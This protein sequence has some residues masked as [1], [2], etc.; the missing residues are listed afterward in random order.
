MWLVADKGECAAAILRPVPFSDTAKSPFARTKSRPRDGSVASRFDRLVS[1][2]TDEERR[3]KRQNL[4]AK[5]E[6]SVSGSHLEIE[7]RGKRREGR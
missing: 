6:E 7:R 5:H 1:D 4:P 2:D 3:E